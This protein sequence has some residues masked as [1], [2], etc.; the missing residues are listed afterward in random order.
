[1]FRKG[2]KGMGAN[3]LTEKCWNYGHHRVCTKCV[4][5]HM[6]AQCESVN[7][8]NITC[9]TCPAKVDMKTVVT[10]LSGELRFK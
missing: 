7:W 5:M 10:F 9:P 3:E 1:M 8:D 4:K 2:A 6:K